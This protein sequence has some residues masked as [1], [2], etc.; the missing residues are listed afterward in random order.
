MAVKLYKA[1]E[2]HADSLIDAGKVDKTSSWSFS[3][4][5][6]DALLGSGDDWTNYARFHL[7]QDA[8]EAEKTKA[9]FKYPHGKEGKVYRSAL[10]A[11][12]SRAS[13]QD[14]TDIFDAAGRLLEKIDKGTEKEAMTQQ[15]E[16][17]AAHAEGVVEGLAQGE[18][19]GLVK[20][21]AAERARI[22]SILGCDEAKG[23]D[24]S[25][26][27]L[28]MNTSMSLEDA[29]G[30][31]AAIPLAPAPGANGSRMSQTPKP[32]I[33][34]GGDAPD[35]DPQAGI[36]AMWGDHVKK[37]NASVPGPFAR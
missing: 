6:G 33:T 14:A 30:I 10:V 13:Q 16:I 27:H 8:E 25:A 7:G 31:L 36:D 2:S 21:S 12:R 3:A 1:G 4:E 26:S 35:A 9:R 32:P 20:G 18:A 28:A 17:T 15:L 19:A 22:K 29:K 37:L 5:D 24:A 34:A 23:R 11:I